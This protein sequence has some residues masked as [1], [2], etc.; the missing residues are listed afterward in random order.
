MDLK[1]ETVVVFT[2]FAGLQTQVCR[3][4]NPGLKAYKPRFEGPD[5]SRFEGP[6]EFPFRK[7]GQKRNLRGG[8]YKYLCNTS[9]ESVCEVTP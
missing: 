9:G 2:R 7:L 3:P 6:D 5:E 1:A 8:I 4:T